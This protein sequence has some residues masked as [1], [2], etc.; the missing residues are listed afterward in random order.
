MADENPTIDWRLLGRQ[1]SDIRL[2]VGV[3]EG[4]MLEVEHDIKILTIAVQNL[5]EETREFRKEMR[6]AFGII[7]GRLAALE[8]R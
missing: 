2:R 3:L 7:S 5:A 8:E 6:E 4:R 1:V